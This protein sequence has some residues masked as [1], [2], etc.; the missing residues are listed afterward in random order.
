MRPSGVRSNKRSPSALSSAERGA[1]E[2]DI[3]ELPA[4][5]HQ[6]LGYRGREYASEHDT[7]NALLF[8]CISDD[9]ADM[10][11]GDVDDLYF[12][13]PRADLAKRQFNGVFSFLG[14]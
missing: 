2:R 14:D 10:E 3:F 1:Y 6:L 12:Y 9:N 13:I 8:Q 11:W 4:G 7:D 5:G